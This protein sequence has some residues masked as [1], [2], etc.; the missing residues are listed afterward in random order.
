VFL[1]L[2]LPPPEV[3][4][5]VPQ[6]A[7]VVSNRVPILR[8]AL[9]AFINDPDEAR[10]RGRAA[11]KNVLERYGLARF[12]ADWDRAFAEAVAG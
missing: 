10:A 7:G 2:A 4:E 3:V 6:E 11:R 12:L 9:R 1:V 5:A 8:D